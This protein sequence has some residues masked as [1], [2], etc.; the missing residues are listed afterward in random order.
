MKMH[1]L[2]LEVKIITH[3]AWKNDSTLHAFVKTFTKEQESK[4][5]IYLLFRLR[6]R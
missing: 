3:L 4:K 2:D 1:L 6:L 5:Y